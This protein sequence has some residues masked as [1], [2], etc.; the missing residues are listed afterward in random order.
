MNNLAGVLRDQGNYEE[1]VA[2]QLLLNIPHPILVLSQV[3]GFPKYTTSNTTPAI[4]FFGFPT[5]IRLKIY[6]ELLVHS[7]PIVF[8]ADSGPSSPPLFR[9]KRDGLYPALLRVNKRAHS[10]ASPLLYSNNRFWF[11]NI[12]TS[13]PSATDSAHIAPFLSQIG[14]QASLIRHIYIAFSIFDDYRRG[15]ARLHEAHIKNLELIRD[16]CTS[17]TT[18]ELL[19]TFPLE[20]ANYALDD[21][22]IAAEALDLLDTRFKAIP[23]LKEIIA[24]VHVYGEEDLSDNLMKK[25][26]DCGWTVEIIK[27]P[28]KV[29]ICHKAGLEFDNKEDYEEYYKEYY[30][31]YYKEYYKE[32]MNHK[33]LLDLRR[34]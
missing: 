17:I 15:R 19:L 16:T 32:Y 1:A 27:L 22:P 34:E 12:F 24:N 30:E 23:S 14:S 18:L 7:E 20:C 10:E 29:W 11:P 21:S 33:L 9:S 4:N 28:K 6:S 2:N 5:E 8:V 25:M 26:R 13:I 3:R 31:E